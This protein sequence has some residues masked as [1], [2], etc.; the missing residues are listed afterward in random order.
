MPNLPFFIARR[1]LF[2]KKSHN[3]INIISA[4]SV[5][6][7]A[8]GTAA[9]IIILS[10]YNGFDSLVRESM[11]EIDPDVLISTEKG[12]TF[13]AEG[14]AYDWIY[15]QDCVLNMSS[16]LEDN[17]YISYSGR[18]SIATAKGVD[19]VYE[20]ETPLHN[21]MVEGEF[22]L[23]KQDVPLCVVGA[24]FAAEMG[25]SSRFLA[26]LELYY[27][28]ASKNF[29]MANPNASLRTVKAYPSGLYSITSGTENNLV[30]IPIELMREL[31]GLD[32]E[33]SG[34]EI[35][36]KEGVTHSDQ[37][38]F[39]KELQEKLGP[40]YKVLDRYKQNESLYKMMKYEKASVF[41]I[42]IFVIII[43]AFNI[44]SSLTMLMI[45]KE[46]DIHTLRCLGADEKLTKKIFVL[47]GWMI[48]LFGMI[49]GLIVGCIVVL[50]QQQFGILKMPGSFTLSAYPVYLQLRDIILTTIA[51]AAIGYITAYI[52]VHV[53]QIKD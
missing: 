17:V 47:E 22:S 45:E 42:M 3:V 14:Q 21:H 2:A 46:E 12:K 23:H 27:P 44:L 9:L 5:S 36:F 49:C 11:S 51:V 48:S 52:P 6:G 15:D 33:V 8:I 32:K 1:Y 10:V 38:R 19:F 24:R 43:V 41:L 7:M 37:K 29:S 13:I 4:I 40:D 34:I 53:K 50:I 20:E 26:G 39:I 30:I 31:M 35:R 28:D 25:I 16:I 18:N